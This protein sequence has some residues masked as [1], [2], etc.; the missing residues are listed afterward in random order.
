MNVLHLILGLPW[1]WSCQTVD[2]PVESCTVNPE[3]RTVLFSE[4]PLH[5]VEQTSVADE[6]IQYSTPLE[7]TTSLYSTNSESMMEWK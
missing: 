2:E 5:A 1:T 3:V 7:S 6:L 4:T